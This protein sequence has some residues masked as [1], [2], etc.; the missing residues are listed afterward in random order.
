MNDDTGSIPERCVPRPRASRNR[1]P[2]PDRESTAGSVATLRAIIERERRARPRRAC[3]AAAAGLRDVLLE[4]RL[5]RPG[6]CVALYVSRPDEPG[7][8]LLRLALRRAGVPVLLSTFEG[9]GGSRWVLDGPAVAAPTRQQGHTLAEAGLIVIPALAVDT[10]G[11][12]LG[13]TT[14]SVAAALQ[15][16]DPMASIMAAVFDTELYDAAVES[17][18]VEPGG[19][20]VWQVVTPSR[21]VTLAGVR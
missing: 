1:R 20:T 14:G 16:A 3:R 4:A 7:T 18:P 15:G 21:V 6:G 13:R 8:H 19:L 5:V 9:A 2:A 12:R 17:V 11:H 10:L